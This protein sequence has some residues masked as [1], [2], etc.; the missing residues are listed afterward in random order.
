[1]VLAPALVFVRQAKRRAGKRRARRLRQPQ[2]GQAGIPMDAWAGAD[3]IFKR[4][5]ATQIR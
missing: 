1:M 3:R 2:T 5:A 4:K